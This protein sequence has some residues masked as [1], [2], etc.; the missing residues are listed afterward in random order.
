MSS[1]KIIDCHT[2]AYPAE[3]VES[4]RA[5]AEAQGE[6]HWAELVAPTG[7]KSIQ[8][9]SDPETMLAS[10][11]AAGVEQAVLLGWYWTRESVC[12][13]HNV[14]M[15]EWI[16]AAPDRLIGFAAIYPNE[17]VVDQLEA[18][19]DLGFRGVGELHMGVQGFKASCPHW[20][21]MAQW[22]VSNNWPINFH[23]TE[24]AGHEH[25]GAVATPLQEFVRMAEAEPELKMILAHW[26]GGLAYFEQNPKL[27]KILRNVYYD[28]AA[29]PLLYD[30]SIFKQ[31]VQL[32]GAQK[33]LFGS[34]Y[35]L[36]I[37]PRKQK[38]PDMELF[39]ETIREESGLDEAE[40]EALLGGNFR[41]LVGFYS[42]TGK[43]RDANLD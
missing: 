26:G 8:G 22:C 39:I 2:H 3:V 29:S 33:L 35:P 18:A 41:R 5:W 28:T 23:V 7:R 13:W 34:D 31:M 6:L 16:Q 37:Y 30:M 21:A 1:T 27:R 4:P 38:A 20:Q 11:D 9:W 36:R 42:K 43:L 32:V 19:K 25:P 15:A 12:R 24:T 10:M 40:L 17:N 14:A